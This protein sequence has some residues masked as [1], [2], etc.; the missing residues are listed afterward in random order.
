M[1]EGVS[2]DNRNPA[3]TTRLSPELRLNPDQ[4]APGLRGS[5]SGTKLPHSLAAS[6]GRVVLRPPRSPRRI[7]SSGASGAPRET[8]VPAPPP[9][10]LV[11]ARILARTPAREEADRFPAAAAL[12]RQVLDADGHP[13]SA[14]LRRRQAPQVRLRLG[15]IIAAEAAER[16]RSERGQAHRAPAPGPGTRGGPG[17]AAAAREAVLRANWRGG[18]PPR[19]RP[20]PPSPRLR[21]PVLGRLWLRRRHRLRPGASPASSPRVAARPAKWPWKVS[22]GGA[23]RPVSSGDPRGRERMGLRPRLS[24]G[25]Q[26]GSGRAATVV[27]APLSGIPRLAR[28]SCRLCLSE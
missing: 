19:L 17:R 24:A 25:A 11:A 22:R 1:C 12:G 20:P 15:G 4:P 8:E 10:L 9:P 13:G 28:K 18:R 21:S 3:G 26:V 6:A 16:R 27:L 14:G 7:P 23:E 5:R 2:A